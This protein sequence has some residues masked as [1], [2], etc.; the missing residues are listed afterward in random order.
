MFN[1]NLPTLKQLILPGISKLELM[2]QRLKSSFRTFWFNSISS[3]K[4]GS[5][6]WNY[7]HQH[8]QSGL[9]LGRK[10][11]VAL[12]A[13]LPVS[14]F[15]QTGG[16]AKFQEAA[17]KITEAIQQISGIAVLLLLVAGFG[18]L[19]WGVAPRHAL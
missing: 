12:W 2:L 16:V 6:A 15:A 9:K 18:L 7:L 14:V 17:K 1:S 5:V 11:L 8:I 3:G 19:M 4:F 10:F 13:L